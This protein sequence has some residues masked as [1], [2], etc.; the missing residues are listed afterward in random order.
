[1]TIPASR[2]ATAI[3]TACLLPGER[4]L[5]AGRPKQGFAL[6]GWDI[7]NVPVAAVAAV[8]GTMLTIAEFRQPSEPIAPFIALF[9]ALVGYYAAVV[10]FFVDRWQRS[11]TY[12]ALTDQRAIIL[13]RKSPPNVRS[14]YLNAL[15]EVTYSHRSDGTGTLEFDRPGYGTIQGR[16]DMGR[17]AGFPFTDLWLTPAFEMV[18]NGREVR[19][20]VLQARDVARAASPPALPTTAQTPN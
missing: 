18:A 13:T 9:M 2:D 12:Y 10:R 15:K 11:L 17:G 6:R 8:V 14:V 7:V 3:I 16:Y 19:D 1:M 4:L 20:L 5:W